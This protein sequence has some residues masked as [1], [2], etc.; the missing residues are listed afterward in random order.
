M[1][2]IETPTAAPEPLSRSELIRQI[3]NALRERRTARSLSL[4]KVTQAIKIRLPYLDALEK[5]EWDQLPGEV[6]VRG[7]IRRYAQYLGLDG[8]KLIAPYVS[9]SE[10]P[11][12]KKTAPSSSAERPSEFGRTQLVWGF[13]GIVFIIGFLKVIKQDRTSPVKPAAALVSSKA[14]AVNVPLA[15]KPEEPAPVLAKHQIEVF[16]PY[17]LWL[18]VSATE[19]NFEGFIPQAAT[20]TWKGEGTF[21]VRLGHTKQVMLTFDGQHV[22]LGEDQKKIVLPSNEN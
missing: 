8:D 17:P 3:S 20:W 16:S 10:S 22:L 15:A 5:G 21:T 11:V 7:F 14:E 13:L 9:I 4:E 19:K 6:F 12:E 1:S 18:R 2:D